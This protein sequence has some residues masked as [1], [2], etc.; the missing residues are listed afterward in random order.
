MIFFALLSR[1]SALVLQL[2]KLCPENN[3]DWCAG[4]RKSRLNIVVPPVPKATER[5]PRTAC[6]TFLDNQSDPDLQPAGPSQP[7]TDMAS[8]PFGPYS[9]GNSLGQKDP[10]FLN[11]EVGDNLT[12]SKSQLQSLDSWAWVSAEPSPAES[13]DEL[14]FPSPNPDGETFKEPDAEKESRR[15]Q[16]KRGAS[17]GGVDGDSSSEYGWL[18]GVGRSRRSSRSLSG[19]SSKK[20]GFEFKWIDAVVKDMKG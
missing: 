9:D 14:Y 13:R 5:S 2:C 15:T 11:S 4:Q 17:F 16:I 7:I 8:S 19:G 10:D 6:S 18:V 20:E 12:S 3:M 1:L